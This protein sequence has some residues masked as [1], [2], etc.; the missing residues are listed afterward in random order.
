MMGQEVKIQ[1]EKLNEILLDVEA[2]KEN[3]EQGE[4]E[5]SEAEQ[6]SRRHC[7]KIIFLS[8]G[9]FLL[10]AIIITIIVLLFIKKNN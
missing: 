6:G 10:V 1:G 5:I 9:I 4:N 7:K 8:L 3:A 2:A